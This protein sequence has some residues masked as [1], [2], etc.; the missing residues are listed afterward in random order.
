[1]AFAFWLTPFVEGMSETTVSPDMASPSSASIS[2]HACCQCSSWTPSGFPA[3]S[4][5]ACARSLTRSWSNMIVFLNGVAKSNLES[6]KGLRLC[7]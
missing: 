7:S 5:I 6:A 4:Q 1:M 3:L 2:R